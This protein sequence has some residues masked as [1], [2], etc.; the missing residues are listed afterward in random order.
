MPE[1]FTTG[2]NEVNNEKNERIS[3]NVAKGVI[4]AENKSDVNI[5]IMIFDLT[6][7]CVCSNSIGAGEK[8]IINLES[9][10]YIVNGRKI[11]L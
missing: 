1:G 6:G 4:I 5:N 11:M 8:Q 3:I 10:I 2:I 7:R 9:G